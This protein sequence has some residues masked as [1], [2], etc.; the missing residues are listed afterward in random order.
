L[1][2]E[3]GGGLIVVYPT[4]R[5]KVCTPARTLSVQDSRDIDPGLRYQIAAELNYKPA[6]G[7]QSVKPFSDRGQR[8]RNRCE[9]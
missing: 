9:I 3:A 6:T 4:I 2:E 7:G 1:A 8:F 5:H